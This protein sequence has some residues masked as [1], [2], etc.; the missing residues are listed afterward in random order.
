MSKINIS[1]EAEVKKDEIMPFKEMAKFLS[2]VMFIWLVIFSLFL[3]FYYHGKLVTVIK[4]D[5]IFLAVY[6]AVLLIIYIQG[7]KIIT[8]KY[9]V[10]EQGIERSFLKNYLGKNSLAN[11]AI[12]YDK[13]VSAI[14]GGA[15]A[16][17]RFRPWRDI[18]GY[19]IINNGKTAVLYP[20]VFLFVLY[21]VPF[22]FRLILGN[23]KEEVLKLLKQKFP[24]LD[25]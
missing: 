13:M 16:S 6:A 2:Q 24:P 8:V 7:K 9:K 20:R 14:P 19:K 25:R 12:D 10:T 3:V 1:W 4:F 15:F 18:A 17:Q 21:G 5:S 23:K 11:F 22:A